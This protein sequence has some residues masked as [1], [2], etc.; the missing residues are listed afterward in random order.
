[1]SLIT[2]WNDAPSWTNGLGKVASKLRPGDYVK[3]IELDIIADPH[4]PP[5]KFFQLPNGSTIGHPSATRLLLP[6]GIVVSVDQEMVTVLAD[7]GSL[8]RWPVSV[9]EAA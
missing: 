5:D 8:K 7:D 3:P 9:V 1:M 2:N 4:C 6:G